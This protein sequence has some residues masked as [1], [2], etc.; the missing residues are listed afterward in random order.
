VSAVDYRGDGVL[1]RGTLP[2]RLVTKFDRFRFPGV[3]RSA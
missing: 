3:D 1:M 2:R